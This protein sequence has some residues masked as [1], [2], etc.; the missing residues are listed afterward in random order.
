MFR[1]NSNTNYT[2][3]TAGRHHFRHVQILCVAILIAIILFSFTNIFR[4]YQSDQDALACENA[5]FVIWDRYL[6]KCNETIDS[7]TP[8]SEADKSAYLSNVVASLY[9][10]QVIANDDGS[11][12]C[13][14]ICPDGGTYTI[15]IN[16]NTNIVTIDCSADGHEESVSW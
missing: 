10:A 8:L 11:Y 6:I 13:S 2:N 14:G 5:R 12:T 4:K 3:I 15:R 16:S 1:N 7:G 9:D